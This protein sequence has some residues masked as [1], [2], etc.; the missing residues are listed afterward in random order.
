MRYGLKFVDPKSAFGPDVKL[1]VQLQDEAPIVI[2]D[3]VPC[4]CVEEFKYWILMESDHGGHLFTTTTSN[5]LGY[6]GPEPITPTYTLVP[7][8]EGCGKVSEFTLDAGTWQG[9]FLLQDVVM[10]PDNVNAVAV[11][12]T[13][14]NPFNSP[15]GSGYT[16]QMKLDG[17]D[18]G[19]S[20][21]VGPFGT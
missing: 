15:I 4:P 17:V 12:V 21:L 18:F 8:Y 5:I 11:Q 6:P 19:P 13:F 3:A 10:D 14:L 2:P 16:V 9:E 1:G 7:V 20:A